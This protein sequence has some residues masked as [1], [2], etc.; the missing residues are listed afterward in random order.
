MTRRRLKHVSRAFRKRNRTRRAPEC[1]GLVCSGL[2]PRRRSI[3][4]ADG[5]L[6]HGRVIAVARRGAHYVPLASITEPEAVADDGSHLAVK[7]ASDE[8]HDVFAV[9]HSADRMPGI[10]E[11]R[12]KTSVRAVSDRISDSAH[13]ESSLG[14]T[15]DTAQLSSRRGPKPIATRHSSVW[16]PTVSRSRQAAARPTGSNGAV[17]SSSL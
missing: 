2:C 13:G 8:A 3:S 9:S 12:R 15:R 10:R 17:T 11:A 7:L 14:S 16:R 5:V 1:A 4:A 6:P